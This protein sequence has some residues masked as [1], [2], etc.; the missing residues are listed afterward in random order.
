M[1]TLLN[2]GRSSGGTGMPP[3]VNFFSFSCSFW[4][5]WSNS[6]LVP[7]L[8]GWHPPLGNPGSATAYD[9]NNSNCKIVVSSHHIVAIIY[10]MMVS[11]LAK[12][13]LQIIWKQ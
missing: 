5:N 1:K 2:I 4:K 12:S 11:I 7:P 10:Y 6:M 13:L 3:R 9:S 8:W